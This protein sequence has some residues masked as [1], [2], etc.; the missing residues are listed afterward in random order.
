MSRK[1][2]LVV[3]P[4]ALLGVASFASPA[5]AATTTHLLM[6]Q[7]AAFGVLGHSCGGIQEQ[8]YARGFGAGGYPIG[9]AYLKTSCSTGGRGSRPATFTAWASVTWDW[10]GDTRSY[11]RLATAPEGLSTTFSATDT[12]A[13]RIYNVGTSAYLETTNPPVVAPAAPTKVAATLWATEV[14]ESVLLRFQVTWTPAPATAR[15]IT[16]STVTATPL[17]STA[18]VLVTTV[19][20]SA[21]NA[22][23]GP[24][25]P[26]TTYRITV[27]NAD[28]E[29]TSKPSAPIEATTPS[30]DE[31]PV[32]S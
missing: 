3:W 29:G 24:L 9:D 5:S 21:A 4:V 17:A 1:I 22:M 27:T 2:S 14:G 20:G 8:V 19:S 18:P 13:D 31:G 30:L 26:S 7:S 11:S 32:D 23:V 12:H 10:F 16:S 15:L 25:Q 6:S 28:R